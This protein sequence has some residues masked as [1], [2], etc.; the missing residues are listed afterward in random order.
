MALHTVDQQPVAVAPPV[1]AE[2]PPVP[3]EAPPAAVAET[4][5]PPAPA[6]VKHGLN[7]L[8][9]LFGLAALAGASS[10]NGGSPSLPPVGACP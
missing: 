8:P 1:V 10:S 7:L 6:V 4:E 9:L 5:F 2:A 3:V